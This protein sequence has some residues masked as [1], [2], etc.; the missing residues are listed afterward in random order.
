MTSSRTH[1]LREAPA[2]GFERPRAR[3]RLRA[4]LAITSGVLLVEVAGGLASRSLALLADATHMFA[5]I[6]ALIL[7]Y[8][9]MG[10]AERAPT[11][12]HSFGLYRA[13]ILAAFVNAQVLLV[14]AVSILFQAFRRLQNPVEVRTGIMLWVAVAGLAANVVAVRL[15][16]PGR[17]ASLN[18]RAAHLEVVTDLFGSLAV[19]VAALLIPATGWKWLDPVVSIAVAGIILPRAVGLLRRTAHILLEGTPGEIDVPDLRRRILEVP[20]VEAIHDLHF[21]T[22][23]SGMHSASLHIRA[24]ADS[25][26][27][28]V[29]RSVQCLLRESAGVDH[30]TIQVERGA[31]MSCP[32]SNRGH[33]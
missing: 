24:A 33:A 3:R 13:E 1:H 23:T 28:E 18:I 10:L 7:A 11:R 12:R 22:L 25:P 2:E 19:I 4:A 8:A 15:L 21:W 32:P 26:R 29:L 17:K 31:E 20:G 6:A 5:D 30:A 16:S 14:V 27:G 9:A